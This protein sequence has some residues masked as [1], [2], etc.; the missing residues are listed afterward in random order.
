VGEPISRGK[1][2]KVLEP[3]HDR[4]MVVHVEVPRSKVMEI[5]TIRVVR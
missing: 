5:R 2:V 4:T 3:M 1:V